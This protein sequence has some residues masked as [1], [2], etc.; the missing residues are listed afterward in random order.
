[1]LTPLQAHSLVI[2]TLVIM[3]F[4]WNWIREA[5]SFVVKD[6]VHNICQKDNLLESEYKNE[7]ESYF[8]QYNQPFFQGK[9]KIEKARNIKK[10]FE[11]SKLI[12]FIH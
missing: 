6:A 10:I 1:M 4:C 5:L 12:E 7:I 3:N 9:Q 11:K 2:I 8:S